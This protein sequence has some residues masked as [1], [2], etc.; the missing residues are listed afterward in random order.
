MPYMNTKHLMISS[1]LHLWLL[2]GLATTFLPQEILNNLG[3]NSNAGRQ[4]LSRLRALFYLGFAMMNWMAKSVLIGGIYA[5]D[6]WQ[7]VT[8]CTLPPVLLALIKF[9]MAGA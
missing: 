8:S 5:Q 6:H 2:S 1:A 4:F 3:L 7:W 9:A